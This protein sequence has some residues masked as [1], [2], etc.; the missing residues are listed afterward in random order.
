MATSSSTKKDSSSSSSSRWHNFS[1]RIST[2]LASALLEWLLILFL[3]ITAVFSYVITKFASYCK[4]KAPC[5]FCSR[6]DH[7]LG[8]ERNGYYLDLICSFHK[9]EISS[10]VYCCKHDKLVNIQGVC[11][12]CILSAATVDKSNAESSEFLVGDKS[13]EDE[14]GSVFDQD[15]PLLGKSERTERTVPGHCSCCSERFAL[16]CYDR[17]FVFTESRTRSREVDFDVADDGEI[18][19]SLYERISAKKVVSVRD[20]RVRNDRADPLSRVGYTE[21]K[22]NSDTESEYE[23]PLSDDDGVSVPVR[24]TDDTE[25]DIRVPLTD[26][27]EEDKRVPCE[28]VELPS[29]DDS[30]EDLTSGKLGTSASVFEP[31]LSEPGMQV[32]NTDICGIKTVAAAVESGNGLTEL[33]WQKIERSAVCPSSSEATPFNNVPTLSNKTGVPVEVSKENDDLRTD[34]EGLTSEQGPSM[35]SEENIKSGNKL[36]ASEEGLEPTIASSDVGQQNPNLLDLGDAYK[37]AVGNRGRQLSGMLAEHWLG[38][39]SSRVNEDLKILMSQFSAT[40]GTD[41]SFNDISPRLSI[42]SEEAKSSDVSNST[43]MQ[44]LQKMI[45]LERNESGLSLDGSIV[46]EIEGESP[47]DKLK[48]QVDHDRKLMNALYKELEEERNASAI[49][50]SQALAM[51]TRLQ[52]EKATLHMEALQHLRMMD[53]QSEYEMEALQNANDLLA[54]KEKEI[55][56]LEAKVEFY[57]KNFPNETLLENTVEKNSEMKVKDIGLDHSQCTFVENNG[58]VPEKSV[59]ENPNIY[60]K[61]DIL[62]TSAEEKN[63]QS[64]KSSLVEFPDEKL[65]ISQRLKKL[66]KQVYF[67]LNTHHSP[68]NLPNSEN[69]GKEVPENSENLD[70]NLLTEDSLP[71]FKLNSDAT[72][73]DQSSKKPPVCKQNGEIESSGCSSPVLCENSDLA[74]TR[75]VVSDFIERLQAL[76]ADHSFLEHT[77][78]LLS[79]GGEGLKLLQEIADRLQQLRMIGIRERDHPVA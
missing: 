52:E 14:S 44:I 26:D 3:F 22:I 32:E 2:S 70:N 31:L 21:L 18:E 36:K 40:R 66:E 60:D 41:M 58:S 49:A 24:R 39:D 74:S 53:E 11:E 1:T 19:S 42:N 6:I 8:K 56:D 65:Y 7:V 15:H 47:V 62:L 38:K 12:T 27:T 67:F 64:V 73:D 63:I 13:V 72:I 48:R 50:A 51:I 78:N 23:V 46:G 34:E 71:S 30:N 33:K 25:E 4:L 59:A 54:E 68:D 37:L 16:N 79:E 69:I 20:Q 45:S 55:E 5:L 61:T 77:I 76:E 28:Y 35:E 17:N 29:V 75:S 43:G 9:S 10:L 57:R